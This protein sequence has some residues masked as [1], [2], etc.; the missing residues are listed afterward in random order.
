M[1]RGF[2]VTG[3]DTGVGKTVV[4]AAV[5]CRWRDQGP[6]RYW[7]PIQTGA[8]THDDACEVARLAR[9]GAGEVLAAGV[10]LPLPLSPHLAAREAGMAIDLSS[11]VDEFRRADSA[12]IEPVSWVVEGAGGVL[13]PIDDD[14]TMRDLMAGFGLRVLVVART[15]LGTINHTLLTLEAL[16]ARRLP[17]AGVVLVGRA[18]LG[19]RSTIERHAPVLG[20]MPVF[21]PLTPEAVSAWAASLDLGAP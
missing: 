12:S 5:V 4:A 19:V 16:H 18:Q 9:C 11:L 10:R 14:R 21:A 3:T 15:T 8:Q 13:V 1:P 20:E 6:V 17:V 7:K 2:F